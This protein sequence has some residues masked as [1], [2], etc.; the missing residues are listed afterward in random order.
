MKMSCNLSSLIIGEKVMVE[1]IIERLSHD[2]AFMAQEHI[3][4]ARGLDL[5]EGSARTS[6]ELIAVN[7]MRE[8]LN[9]VIV[10]EVCL[11]R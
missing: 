5:L 9:E 6:E 3:T 1:E 2:L 7:V 11:L 10:D 8:S 4:L